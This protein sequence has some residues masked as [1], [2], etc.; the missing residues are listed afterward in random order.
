MAGQG[1][2]PSAFLTHAKS[3]LENGE[4]S[5]DELRAAVLMTLPYVGYP[6][7]SPLYFALEKLLAELESTA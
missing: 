2:D 4:M 1:A 5:G 6:K 3:T 7:A